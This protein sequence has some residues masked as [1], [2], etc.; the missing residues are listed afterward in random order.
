MINNSGSRNTNNANQNTNNANFNDNDNINSNH[1]VHPWGPSSPRPV[2]QVG[3]NLFGTCVPVG[4][5][6][7][8]L[9]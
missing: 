8:G 6:A 4:F 1:Y 3:L 9:G 7:W 2:A 5:G